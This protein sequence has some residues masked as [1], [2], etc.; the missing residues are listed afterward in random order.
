MILLK[1][2]NNVVPQNEIEARINM[3]WDQIFIACS[4]YDLDTVRKCYFALRALND[5][6]TIR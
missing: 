3:Y 4:T 6:I 5:K 2:K 1:K